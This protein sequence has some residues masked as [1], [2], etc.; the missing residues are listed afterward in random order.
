MSTE[1]STPTKSTATTPERIGTIVMVVSLLALFFSFVFPNLTATIKT[2]DQ[3]KSAMVTL[4]ILVLVAL[5][6]GL[7]GTALGHRHFS[8]SA[9][10]AAEFRRVWPQRCSSFQR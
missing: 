5:A 1:V 3:I 7:V 8:G 4:V 6:L 9:A 2:Q 10:S